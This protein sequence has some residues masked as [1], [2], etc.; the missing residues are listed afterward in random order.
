MSHIEFFSCILASFQC[1]S[2]LAALLMKQYICCFYTFWFVTD[3]LFYAC[4]YIMVRCCTLF[5]KA[6]SCGL[7]YIDSN[8]GIFVP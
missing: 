2:F 5:N 6:Q 3:S 7:Y 8:L 4:G 1:I